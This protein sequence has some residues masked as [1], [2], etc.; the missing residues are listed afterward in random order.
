MNEI[1]RTFIFLTSCKKKSS[2]GG[3]R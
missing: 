1:F 2:S 3:S